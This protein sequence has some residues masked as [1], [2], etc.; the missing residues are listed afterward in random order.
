MNGFQIE[1]ASLKLIDSPRG[2]IPMVASVLSW[3]IGSHLP[4]DQH[5]KRT[6]W[7]E[8]T[9]LADEREIDIR[10]QAFGVGH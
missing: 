6:G 9:Y 2:Q 3:G 4:N 8:Q 5:P 1:P 7:H 10:L